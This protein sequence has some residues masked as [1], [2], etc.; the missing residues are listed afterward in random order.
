MWTGQKADNQ[1][2]SQIGQHRDALPVNRCDGMRSTSL[3][4]WLAGQGAANC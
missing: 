4:C 2:A 1:G 3:W